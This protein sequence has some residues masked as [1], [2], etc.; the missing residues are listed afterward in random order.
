MGTM[1]IED[2]SAWGRWEYYVIDAWIAV[3]VILLRIVKSLRGPM[4]MS[5]WAM[6]SETRKPRYEGAWSYRLWGS[7]LY[8]SLVH[9]HSRRY[10]TFQTEVVNRI[11]RVLRQQRV[12]VE[13]YDYY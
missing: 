12:H 11:S 13:R 10:S 4:V 7:H 6:H 5:L 3:E 2:A 8:L 9:E 1:R